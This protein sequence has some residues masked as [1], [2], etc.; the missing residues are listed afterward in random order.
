MNNRKTLNIII[1]TLLIISTVSG[2]ILALYAYSLRQASNEFEDLAERFQASKI[3]APQ[4]DNEQEK[5]PLLKEEVIEEEG[6]VSIVF[7]ELYNQN[8]DI[9]AWISIPDT[10]VNYPVMHTPEKPEY[11]L[12]RN[13]KKEY[14]VSGVPFMDAK[15]SLESPTDNVLIHGHNMKNGS[16]FAQL[17]AYKDEAFLKEH[18]SIDLYTFDQKRT[19]D[20]LSVFPTSAYNNGSNLDY[21]NFTEAKDEKAFDHY[22]AKAKE[23]SLFETGIEAQ[24]GDQLMTLSTCAYHTAN[25][26]F[27]VIARERLK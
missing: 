1:I 24:Y 25:G 19:Y 13:F 4:E 8:I 3:K 9:V 15:S 14:S 26:R 18:P 22:V 10:R 20:I 2:G 12:Y 6:E 27:V 11:Y 5:A 17:L 21:H 23:L 7:E 16:M